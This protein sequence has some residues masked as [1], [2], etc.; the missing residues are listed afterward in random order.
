MKPNPFVTKCPT[1]F[2][3]TKFTGCHFFF[4][5]V[6]YLTQ[7]G[8]WSLLRYVVV[9]FCQIRF[10]SW[11]EEFFKRKCSQQYFTGQWHIFLIGGDP[12]RRSHLWKKIW[13][14]FL[15]SS[16]FSRIF[17]PFSEQQR[18]KR[19]LKK[20]KKNF[21]KA[22]VKR[23]PI[24]KCEFGNEKLLPLMHYLFRL[25]PFCSCLYYWVNSPSIQSYT[26]YYYSSSIANYS[27]TR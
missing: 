11:P 16:S 18:T 10:Q 23:G 14:F 19:S 4:F 2:F 26:C 8:N 27:D 12:K 21:C 20:K 5:F 22:N 15:S 13:V 9:P 1:F 24:L 6:F 25:F 3:K 7:I 17:F